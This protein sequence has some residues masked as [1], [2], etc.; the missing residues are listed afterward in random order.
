MVHVV[1]DT[2]SQADGAL[3]FGLHATAGSFL[4]SASGG[5]AS[6]QELLWNY[7]TGGGGVSR[8]LRARARPA[9]CALARPIILI[10][11][12][13][14]YP[15]RGSSPGLALGGSSV[16]NVN[17]GGPGPAQSLGKLRGALSISIATYHA[18]NINEVNRIARAV[19][20]NY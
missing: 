18:C 17:S 12:D 16:V 14:Y 3:L 11:I 15:D 10:I 20:I 8:L 6:N 4:L 2:T 13:I 7:A 19:I 5:I 1:D 9:R